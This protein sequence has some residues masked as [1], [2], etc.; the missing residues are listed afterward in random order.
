MCCD[1][2]CNTQ[3]KILASPTYVL[4]T[5]TMNSAE[6]IA[7]LESVITAIT[8]EIKKFKGSVIVRTKVKR[9]CC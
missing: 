1:F 2:C 5:T 9:R 4:Q 7:L 8:T 6:G 3:V